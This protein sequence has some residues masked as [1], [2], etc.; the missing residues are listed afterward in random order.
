MSRSSQLIDE[1][2]FL[3]A[4][5]LAAKIKAKELSPVEVTEHFLMRI[6]RIDPNL[7]AF[8]TVAADQA[9]ESE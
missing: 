5:E 9:E 2:S 3:P 1:I 4:W 6:D 8:I 7:K